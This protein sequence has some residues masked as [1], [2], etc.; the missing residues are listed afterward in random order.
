[1]FD[2]LIGLCSSS[3]NTPAF[4]FIGIMAGLNAT[5]ILLGYIAAKTE[6]KTDDLWAMRLNKFVEFLKTVLDFLIAKRK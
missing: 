3:L 1:M 5:S 2:Q 4:W 6:T